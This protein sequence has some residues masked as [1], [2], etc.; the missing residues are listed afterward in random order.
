MYLTH[1]E[2]IMNEGPTVT[3]RYTMATFLKGCR[4]LIF[5]NDWYEK[6]SRTLEALLYRAEL[7]CH[8]WSDAQ[9]ISNDDSD[10]ENSVTYGEGEER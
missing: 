6:P 9:Q 10:S 4:D 1:F 8:Q 5:K 3:D 7:Y 2:T